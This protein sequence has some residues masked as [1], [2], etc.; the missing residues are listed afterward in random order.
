MLF[1]LHHCE[2]PAIDRNQ[3]ENQIFHHPI[4]LHPDP[5]LEVLADPIVAEHE[6]RNENA[7]R[8]QMDSQQQGQESSENNSRTLT[9][10]ERLDEN[11]ELSLRTHLRGELPES[12]GDEGADLVPTQETTQHSEL[13]YGESN[14]LAL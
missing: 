1:F 3:Q 6:E 4:Q 11:T 13:L 14:D 12:S 10:A 2:L 5:P 9:G 8:E 7:Q